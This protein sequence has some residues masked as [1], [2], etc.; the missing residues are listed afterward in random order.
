MNNLGYDFQSAS[1]E[2]SIDGLYHHYRTSNPKHIGAEQK[3]SQFLLQFMTTFHQPI[4]LTGD[5][6]KA[7]FLGHCICNSAVHEGYD[8]LA[9]SPGE[10]ARLLRDPSAED[11]ISYVGLIAVMDFDSLRFASGSFDAED[12]QNIEEYLLQ[13]IR[14]GW[15]MIFHMSP[16]RSWCS[17]HL[18]DILEMNCVHI[19]VRGEN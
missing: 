15:P 5:F 4:W 2:T 11:E 10:L 1:I 6:P 13:F 7:S 19:N 14:S 12:V 16:N 3:F 9:T 17:E 8:V 18:H